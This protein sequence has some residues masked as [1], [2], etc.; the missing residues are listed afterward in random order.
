MVEFEEEYF[1]PIEHGGRIVIIERAPFVPLE[2]FEIVHEQ[3]T[4]WGV[5][6]PIYVRHIE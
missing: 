1:T 4:D 2:T 6:I 5:T 3:A